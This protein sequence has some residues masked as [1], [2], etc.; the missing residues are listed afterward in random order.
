VSGEQA[1]QTQLDAIASLLAKN[2]IKTTL[3]IAL[4]P[5]QEGTNLIPKHTKVAV[6]PPDRVNEDCRAVSLVLAYLVG[7]PSVE[8]GIEALWLDVR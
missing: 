1:P 6:E 2:A 7:R 3:V 5:A 4:R 8:R